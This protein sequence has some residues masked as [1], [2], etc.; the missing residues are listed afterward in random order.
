MLLSTPKDLLIDAVTALSRGEP[1][2]ALPMV[3]S[4]VAQLQ[5]ETRK[6]PK[7][8]NELMPLLR[9]R[10]AAGPV[11]RQF[12]QSLGLTQAQAAE[13]SQVSGPYL[14]QVESGKLPMSQPAIERLFA[15]MAARGAN[16]I[17]EGPPP[18]ALLK[19]RRLL[20]LTQSS[21][22]SKLGLKETIV[23]R[24]ETGNMPVSMP[25]AAA[26]RQLAQKYGR[27]LDQLAA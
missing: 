14:A 23:R 19:L 27:D 17:E 3:E 22:A 8:I 21:I 11:L 7:A 5:R 16:A 2:V 20:G 1:E 13:I 6:A 18:A 12:R 15:W 4:A 24:M 10:E 25:A 9:R 26:Y